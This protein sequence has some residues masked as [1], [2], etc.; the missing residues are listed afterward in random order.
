MMAAA[1]TKS[2]GRISQLTAGCQIHNDDFRIQ[3]ICK[4]VETIR[5]QYLTTF[6][7][8]CIR[9]VIYSYLNQFLLFRKKAS[10]VCMWIWQRLA[11]TGGRLGFCWASIRIDQ[12]AGVVGGCI[13]HRTRASAGLTRHASAVIYCSICQK[14]K[15]TRSRWI[16]FVVAYQNYF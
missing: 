13:H 9:W 15:C 11:Q 2:K 1:L 5:T 4:I 12:M 14:Y 16:Y 6:R 10:F 8:S 3:I 7:L